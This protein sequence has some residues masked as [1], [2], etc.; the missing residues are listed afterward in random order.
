MGARRGPQRPGD[1]G[2]LEARFQEPGRRPQ[3][4]FLFSVAPSGRSPILPPW[5]HRSPARRQPGHCGRFPFPHPLSLFIHLHRQELIS[6]KRGE[7]PTTPPAPTV[8]RGSVIEP[9]AAPMLVLSYTCPS[10]ALPFP[11]PGSSLPAGDLLAPRSGGPI[12]V[13][14]LP[15]TTAPPPAPSRVRPARSPILP[16]TDPPTSP[17]L[18]SAP[19]CPGLGPRVSSRPA[20]L[21]AAVPLEGLQP[22]YALTTLTVLSPSQGSIPGLAR[23]PDSGAQLPLDISTLILMRHPKPSTSLIP[24]ATS[25]VAPPTGNGNAVIQVQPNNIQV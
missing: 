16:G 12:S 4:R 14:V 24:H 18:L 13:S 11:S 10:Q 19:R 22:V 6:Q 9:S 23:A 25:K 20:P 17:G 1:D 2:V 15:S 7:K 5:M 3:M 21:Q 8:A